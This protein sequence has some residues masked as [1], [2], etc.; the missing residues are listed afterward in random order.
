MRSRYLSL[1]TPLSE[2]IS[3]TIS[4]EVFDRPA[5]HRLAKGPSKLP[6][7]QFDIHRREERAILYERATCLVHFTRSKE[8]NF[9][10][11]NRFGETV[12]WKQFVLCFLRR[13]ESRMRGRLRSSLA[14]V[15]RAF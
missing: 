7:K 14:D 2:S 10:L 11:R 6:E 3:I 4:I 9:C 13:V 12:I 15:V 1:E 8:N 5:S